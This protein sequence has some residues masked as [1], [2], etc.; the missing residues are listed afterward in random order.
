MWKYY[1]SLRLQGLEH[2]VPSDIDHKDYLTA[3]LYDM[4]I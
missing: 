4:K 2:G 1:N 3:W